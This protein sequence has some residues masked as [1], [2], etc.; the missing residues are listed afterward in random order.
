MCRDSHTA[1]NAYRDRG[2]GGTRGSRGLGRELH[3]PRPGGR[4]EGRRLGRRPRHVAHEAARP[5]CRLKKSPEPSNTKLAGSVPTSPSGRHAPWRVLSFC[6]KQAACELEPQL[7][8]LAE[9]DLRAPCSGGAA[10][11]AAGAGLQAGAGCV[12]SDRAVADAN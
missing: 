2:A 4:S 8:P 1:G 7:D 12:I 3:R 9:G 11:I 6:D 5:G 10:E